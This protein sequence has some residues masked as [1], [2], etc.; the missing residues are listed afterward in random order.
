MAKG[1]SKAKRA[2]EAVEDTANYNVA[3]ERFAAEYEEALRAKDIGVLLKLQYFAQEL[4][5]MQRPLLREQLLALGL[6][7]R[8]AAFVDNLRAEWI[9]TL[10]PLDTVD[11]YG[12]SEWKWFETK[13]LEIDHSRGEMKV[14]YQGWDSKF[15]EVL[16]INETMVCPLNT[17]TKSKAKPVKAI[18]TVAVAEVVIEQPPV[19][20]AAPENTLAMELSGGTISER[21]SRRRNR[22]D[23]HVD[24]GQDGSNKRPSGSSTAEQA[25]ADGKEGKE[26][27]KEEKDH[28][29]WVCTVCGWFEAPDGSDL[30]CCDGEY[31]CFVRLPSV[32]ILSL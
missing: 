18:R 20:T 19:Q 31:S 9:K 4:Y 12:P 10:K 27:E 2:D 6:F 5:T 29:D 30:V 23:A 21:A 28:N 1:K 22:T 15:D 32:E 16:P 17:F 13:I 25:G 26:K 14:H 11:V 3:V 8:N 24:N 7:E